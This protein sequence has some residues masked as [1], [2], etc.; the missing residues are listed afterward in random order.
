MSVDAREILAQ[1][2]ALLDPVFS[3]HGFHFDEESS[4]AHSSDA[5][6]RGTYVRNGRRVELGCR[7]ELVAVIYQLDEMLLTHDAY[8]RAVLGP[9]GSNMYPCFTGDPLDG[10][11]HLKHD[12]ELY[13]SIFLRGSDAQ[14]RQIVARSQEQSGDDRTTLYR[15]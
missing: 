12:L 3:T 11:R 14:F 6:A 13:A 7:D 9:A 2:R 1:G 15:R 4:A 10:F 5:F 8:M